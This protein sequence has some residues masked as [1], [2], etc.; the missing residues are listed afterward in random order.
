L[1]GKKL[2]VI[3]ILIAVAGTALVL[4]ASMKKASS[5]LSNKGL[6]TFTVRQDDLTITVTESGN[7]KAQEST[8][9]FCEVEGRGTEVAELVSEGTIVT[10][11]D[12]KNKKVLCQLNSSDLQDLLSQEKIT[13]S[14]AKATYIE[15]QE[16]Y[17]IQKKQNESD[18]GLAKAFG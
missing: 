15:A 8:D 11:E 1:G 12:V 10:E 16:A 4:V 6:N 5:D 7:V 14:T 2:W 18:I 13:F 3:L 9:I 17:E